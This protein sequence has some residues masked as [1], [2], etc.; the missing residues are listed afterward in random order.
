MKIEVITKKLSVCILAVMLLICTSC[1]SSKE[2]NEISKTSVDSSIW[3]F[4]RTY[5]SLDTPF[6][7]MISSGVQ[8]KD[9][10]YFINRFNDKEGGYKGSVFSQYNS[11]NDE[12]EIVNS[13]KTKNCNF[14]NPENCSS[15]ISETYDYLSYYNNKL[16]ETYAEFDVET[17]MYTYILIEMDMYGK[18]RKEVFTKEISSKNIDFIPYF[19]MGYM[20]YVSGGEIGIV[21]LESWE[22]TTIENQ[23]TAIFN[24]LFTNEGKIYINANNY[25]KAD[26]F[27]SSALFEI[28]IEK[29][30]LKFVRDVDLM[31]LYYNSQF[32]IEMI[33]NQTF[34][35][36]SKTKD[37]VKLS[38]SWGYVFA[39]PKSG[40]YIYSDYIEDSLGNLNYVLF[41]SKGNILDTFARPKEYRTGDIFID[42]TF[43]FGIAEYQ[44]DGS[45]RIV[46]YKE[47]RIENSKFTNLRDLGK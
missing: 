40:L 23:K 13:E 30:E 47:L 8:T 18:N 38:D 32:T 24:N 33:G 6:N 11:E 7:S 31:L 2:T 45:Y 46:G 44:P 41:D 4:E 3:G 21:N 27:Y 43:T 19:T 25:K 9:G 15:F 35:C 1:S 17:D 29:K 26:K 16:Y 5:E 12:F 39:D 34:Y 37:K 42:S 20:I 28:N 22:W 36:D 10:Y 14:D